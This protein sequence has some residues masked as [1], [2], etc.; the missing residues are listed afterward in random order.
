MS[1]AP[2]L[3]D[4]QVLFLYFL[5]LIFV[6]TILLS[7]PSSYSAGSLRSLDALFTAVSAVCVTGLST[8]TTGDFS[9]SGK[10]ILLCLIQAG[11]LGFITFSTLYLFFPGSR[12]SFR[13]TAIIQEYYGS[14][15]IQKPKNII[16]SILGFTLIFEL[17]GILI[18]FPG[19]VR[20]G[21]EHPFFSSVF[22][23]ISAFCN[24]GFSLYSD[25]LTQFQGNPQVLGGV[26]FMI[27]TG[28]LGYMVHW[29]LFKKVSHPG[30]VKLRYHSMI[31]ILFTFILIILGFFVFYLLERHRLFS[32]MNTEDAL[33]AALFQS[34]TTRTAGFNTV[35][36]SG[37]TAPST[38]L[39]LVFML[40]GGGSGS[41][42]GGLK[43]T[44]TF[45][46]FLIIIKGIDD[47]GEIPFLRRRISKE[48]LN[49]ASLYF[50]K[51]M[52]ILIL[53]VFL[54]SLFETIQLKNNIGFLEIL[55]ECISAL[56]TVGLSMGIT[57]EL[58]DLSQLVL[59]CTMFAGRIGLFAIII[60]AVSPESVYNI[61]YPEG[62]VLIG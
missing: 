39:N 25:S 12:F 43:V 18:I 44:T 6:G 5:I 15:H 38:L 26:S 53:S 50:L 8:V 40:I 11:G 61:R 24:A 42:A 32:D 54:V 62:E 41:T 34:I 56:G 23:G 59:I 45:L 14:E 2:Q 55:F 16:R 3:S 29:N 51:A 13:N 57:A 7:L 46:L 27:V 22:H 20:Q 35:D 4:K 47:H 17:S 19:M 33:M 49:R 9:L 28:G 48:L 30:K 58:S 36:Q 31:M 1:R 60:P 52:V 10:I 37:F 21:V